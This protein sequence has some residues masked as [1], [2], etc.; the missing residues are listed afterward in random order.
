MK[1]FLKV[2]VLVIAI[3]IVV[4]SYKLYINKKTIVSV[5]NLNEPIKIGF[6]S[7]LTGDAVV[8][9]EIAKNATEMALGEINESG[10]LKRKLEIIYED[11][12]CNGKD[13]ATAAQKLIN[14][15]RVKI[16]LGGD[17]SSETLAVAPLAESNKVILFSSFSS[18]PLISQAGDYVFRNSPSDADFGKTDAN[19]I[20]SQGIKNIAIITENTDYSQGVRGVMKSIFKQKN[21]DIIA[22]EIFNSGTKDFRTN[23]SKIKPLN[24]EAVYINVGTSPASAGIIAK[25][26]KELGITNVKIFSNPMLADKDAIDAGGKAV[27]GAIFSDGKD[28]SQLAGSTIQKYKEKY[29]KDPAYSYLMT[30]RYDSLYIIKNAIKNCGDDNSDCIKEYLYNMPKYDGTF[31]SYKFDSNGDLD[32]LSGEFAVHKKIINGKPVI[33]SE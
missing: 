5:E 26:M 3:V 24:P 20:V 16:I 10:E 12:K 11:G 28:L 17:C 32:L 31:G 14:I 25:Q 19:F 7:P 2:I 33:V 27:E 9:G 29:Q 4:V 22:D 23:L 21:V 13:A 8:A 18:S 1:K 6:I 30:A 15:D